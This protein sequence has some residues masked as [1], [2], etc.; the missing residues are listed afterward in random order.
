MT[1]EGRVKRNINKML[2]GYDRAV[3]RYMPVPHG[4][5]I[6]AHDYILC[7]KGN[8]ISLEAKRAGKDLTPLQKST[9]V[10]MWHAGGI[11]LRCRNDAEIEAARAILDKLE[12]VH[13]R[14]E[15]IPGYIPEEDTWD[16]PQHSSAEQQGKKAK[17]STWR[18]HG[19]PRTPSERPTLVGSRG[20][21]Q[22]V[23][24]TVTEHDAPDYTPGV[25]RACQLCGNPL[26]REEYQMCGECDFQTG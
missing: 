26:S 12:W 19:S 10:D 7:F 11:V 6:P 3:W 2:A 15:D 25:M 16:Q 5:G 18:D 20:E 4:Y 13:G 24:V 22:G 21:D 9:R 23:T 17:R 8:F 14:R 1:P